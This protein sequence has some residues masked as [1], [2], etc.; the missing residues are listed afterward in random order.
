MVGCGADMEKLKEA[1][2]RFLRYFQK[3]D[4]EVSVALV[5]DDRISELNERY[6]GRREPTDVFAFPS[7]DAEKRDFLGEV[8]IDYQQVA[9]QAP[10]FGH[11]PQ[12]E[13]IFVLIHGL[14]HLLG[15][16]DYTEEDKK[17]MIELGADLIKKLN[18]SV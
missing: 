9:R 1:A 14:L 11:T 18:I 5:G 17:N 7:P 10:E 16:T 4:M 2:D 15:Y 12:Q 6:K 3:E 13:L 8:I